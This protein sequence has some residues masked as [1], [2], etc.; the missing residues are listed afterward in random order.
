ML[1]SQVSQ[2]DAADGDDEESEKPAES[3]ESKQRR[4]E[5]L[6]VLIFKFKVSKLVSH[7]QTLYHPLPITRGEERVWNT[8]IDSAVLVPPESWW[9]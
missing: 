5:E 2:M 8:A 7:S 1:L 4:I 3:E 6:K 9:R